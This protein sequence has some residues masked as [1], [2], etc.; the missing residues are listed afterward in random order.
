MAKRSR[1]A[2]L[3][4]TESERSDASPMEFPALW[5][6][7]CA[8]RRLEKKQSLRGQGLIRRLSAGHSTGAETLK[9]EPSQPCSVRLDSRSTW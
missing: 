6:G 5:M 3:P 7:C 2:P 9:P 8:R 4:V 1:W